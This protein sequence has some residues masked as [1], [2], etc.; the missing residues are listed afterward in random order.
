V[1]TNLTEKVRPTASDLV[2]ALFMDCKSAHDAIADLTSAGFRNGQIRIAYSAEGKQAKSGK[3]EVH[4]PGQPAA[5]EE[6]NSVG[7]KLRQ[8]FMHDLQRSGTDQM[9]GQDGDVS[10][11][12]SEKPYSE[13][14]LRGTLLSMGVAEDRIL[15]LNREMRDDGVLVLVNADL[16]SKEAESI[17]ERNSG[18]IRTDTATEHPHFAG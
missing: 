4:S 6:S 5:P 17:I 13:V 10:S 18:Q 15:L 1:R 8:S 11:S 2:I 9:A 3:N 16:R 12:K 7:W 14:D